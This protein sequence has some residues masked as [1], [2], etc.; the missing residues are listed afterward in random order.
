MRTFYVRQLER[1]LVPLSNVVKF[2][3]VRVV[4]SQ[5][6]CISLRPKP[7]WGDG[8]VSEV[9]TPFPMDVVVVTS[10]EGH[11]PRVRNIHTHLLNDN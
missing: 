11:G 5:D 4:K 7:R 8:K 2:T 6:D 10:G 1:S 9:N 3:I